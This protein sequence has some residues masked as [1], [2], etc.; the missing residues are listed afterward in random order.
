[1]MSSKSLAADAAALRPGA[2]ALAAAAMLGLAN[3]AHAD[4]AWA[5][6]ETVKPAT[7]A[8]RSNGSAYTQ[9]ANPATY[10]SSDIKVYVDAGVVG[11]VKSWRTWISLLPAD[12]SGGSSAEFPQAKVAHTYD[13]GYRPKVVDMTT[14]VE[15]VSGALQGF[16]VGLC[17]QHADQLRSQ[18]LNNTQ[19]FGQDRAIA[20]GVHAHMQA[21]FTSATQL[22]PGEV[23][24][25]PTFQ[26]VC[27]KQGGAVLPGVGG[28]VGKTEARLTAAALELLHNPH[29]N[30]CPATVNAVMTFTSDTRGPFSVRARSVTTN[31]VSAPI[32]LSMEESDK[33]GMVY[34]KQVQR[35]FLVGGQP[36]QGGVVGGQAGGGGLL[37]GQQLPPPGPGG[38]PGGVVAPGNPAPGNV[39]RDSLWVEVI[40]AAPQSIV[41]SPYAQ[42][43]IECP[44]L[45]G[46]GG[47]GAGGFVGA[48]PAQPNMRSSTLVIRPQLLLAP[49]AQPPLRAPLP[50]MRSGTAPR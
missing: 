47:G 15:L 11:R 6:A 33:Q 49:A 5:R 28:V 27:Q 4:E 22:T 3:H 19:I 50:S 43:E 12:S 45:T 37:L 14:H 36:Q 46:V 34:V 25:P 16:V 32:Q 20:V 38:A 42:Y 23:T 30:A 21:E 7:V 44:T 1:M 40:N 26:V 48:S 24:L 29:P 2:I 39:Y 10:L 8:V 31:Q 41:K 13:F 18:G 9:M 35:S 17:N